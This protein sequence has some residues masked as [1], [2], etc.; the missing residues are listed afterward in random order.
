[1]PGLPNANAPSDFR[2]Q[3]GT[4]GIGS[5]SFASFMSEKTAEG[6]GPVAEFEFFPIKEGEPVRKVSIN[7]TEK[8]CGDQFFAKLAVP[9]GVKTGLNA[10]KVTLSFPASPWGKIQPTVYPV[11]VIPMRQH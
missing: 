2:V 11:D 8:C 7:L 9:E 5:G 3:V 1:M 4:P 6:V 10:A